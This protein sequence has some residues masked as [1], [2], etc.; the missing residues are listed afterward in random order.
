[1]IG[2][3]IYFCMRGIS[4]KFINISIALILFFL[5]NINIKKYYMT[6]STCI[7]L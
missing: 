2:R 1:M 7:L 3:W 5:E 6:N 4:N